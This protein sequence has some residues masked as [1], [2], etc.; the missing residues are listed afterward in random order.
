MCSITQELMVDPVMAQD[1]HTYERRAVIRKWI[2]INGRKS[3]SPL[4][5]SCAISGH[6]TNHSV[7]QQIDA[8]VSSG[9]LEDEVY[10]AYL[11]R[12]Q[13]LQAFE[14]SSPIVIKIQDIP[15][16]ARTTVDNSFR[17]K[18]RTRIGRVFEAFATRYGLVLD[19]LLFMQGDDVINQHQIVMDLDLEDQGVIKCARLH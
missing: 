4:V 10:A 19:D 1:G 16:G 18:L 12:L 15:R 6:H 3:N 14:E 17:V 7:K 11:K 5:P 9:E 13:K 8:L 2:N